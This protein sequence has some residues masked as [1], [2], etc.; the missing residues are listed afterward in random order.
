MKHRKLR[1][2]WSVAWGVL[3]SMLIVLWLDS[4]WHLEGVAE[5]LNRMLSGPR[6]YRAAF[7]FGILA[8]A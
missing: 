6:R 1:I 5:P 8:Q 7:A 3:A 2:A 4:Y